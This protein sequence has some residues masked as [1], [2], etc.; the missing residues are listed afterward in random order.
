MDWRRSVVALLWGLL[1]S[2]LGAQGLDT[3]RLSGRWAGDGS[4]M[5]L[6]F[7]AK[8][9]PL[10]FDLTIGP[11]HILTGTVG[12]AV[13]QPCPLVRQGAQLDYAARLTGAVLADRTFRKDHLL[14]MITKTQPGRLEA[15]FQLKSG[16]GFDLTMRPGR[17]VLTRHPE[18]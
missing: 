11:D 7:R 10:P 4:F 16:F 6:K 3:S 12:G 5:N 18:P 8:H 2:A 9:G 1:A 13:I 15:G 17:L 14:L